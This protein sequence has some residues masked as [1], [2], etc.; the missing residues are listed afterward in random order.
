MNEVE[1]VIRANVKD[2]KS[3]VDALIAE[4]ALLKHKIEGL[5][6][7]IEM[8]EMPSLSHELFL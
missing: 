1:M 6:A 2:L 8:L 7:Q 3:Q 4:N 5:E